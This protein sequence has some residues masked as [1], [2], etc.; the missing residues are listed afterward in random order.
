MNSKSTSTSGTY[1]RGETKGKSF[2]IGFFMA[3]SN[4]LNILFWL[5]IY[6]SVL[7]KTADSYSNVQLLLY[8]SGIFVGITLWD[9]TMASVA[10]GARKWFNHKVL[11]WISIIA[12]VI[13]I[14]F[15]LYFGA[16]AFQLL[17]L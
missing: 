3:V 6:G 10:T 5:G 9:L 2:R 17:F 11:Q 4:P 16:Q 13:L 1:A 7:A 12:G 8:S 15:G 14:G